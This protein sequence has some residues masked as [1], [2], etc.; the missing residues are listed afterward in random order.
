MH[1]VFPI[2]LGF[3]LSMYEY[4]SAMF[5]FQKY[6]QCNAQCLLHCSLHCIVVLFSVEV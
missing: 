6:T 4:N 1:I 2:V 3:S 5:N